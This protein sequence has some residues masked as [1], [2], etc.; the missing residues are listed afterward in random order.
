MN[1]IPTH[2]WDAADYL[3][4]QED[5]AAYLEAALEESEP[6]LIAA[7]LGDIARSQDMTHI[8]HETGLEQESLH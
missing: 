7:V 8:A 4:T 1:N 5:V 3:E 6:S 2:P